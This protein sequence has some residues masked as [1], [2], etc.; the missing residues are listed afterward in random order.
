MTVAINSQTG[1]GMLVVD[2]TGS[3]TTHDLGNIANPEGVPLLIV[4]A[5][6]HIVTAGLANSDLHV[7]VGTASAGVGNADLFAD[8]DVAATALTAW[9]G[10]SNAV[11]QG[12][13][14]TPALWTAAKYL[15][16]FTD[17]AYSTGL[18]AK[19]FVRYLRLT[20]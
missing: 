11:A 2:I 15:T 8:A 5:F 14:T 20:D 17:T 6:L 10:A 13:A 3:G 4:E 18:V 16:F 9:K 1:H 12:A 19:L 7:G